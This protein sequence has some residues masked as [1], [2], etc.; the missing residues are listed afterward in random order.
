M[1]GEVGRAGKDN[2]L[3]N[4]SCPP[5]LAGNILTMG[6]KF[7]FRNI[8]QI[9]VSVEKESFEN[10]LFTGKFSVDYTNRLQFKCWNRLD[11]EEK[12]VRAVRVSR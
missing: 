9:K 8:L 6:R 3:H 7:D 5:E 12:Q 4:I 10:L 2:S 1:N 11:A